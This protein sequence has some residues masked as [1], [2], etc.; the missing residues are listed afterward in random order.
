MWQ[1]A[2]GVA[3]I[4]GLV[5]PAYVVARP[6]PGTA[7]RYFELLFRTAAYMSEVDKYSRGIVKDRNRLYWEDFKR[8]PSCYPPPHE[9]EQIVS[10]IDN[11]CGDVDDGIGRIERELSLLSEFRA[12]LIADVVTGKL[13][14]REAAD[15][16]PEE[17]PGLDV[18][19]A[20]EAEL[21][22]AGDEEE[23]EELALAD[24]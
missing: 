6:A 10:A 5:S 14:V 15:D 18:S 23:M 11:A 4:D 7:T 19:D 20:E 8:M 12:R 24:E 3:P 13:D 22:L 9:Q 17:L 2:V 1:G 16:L 21:E